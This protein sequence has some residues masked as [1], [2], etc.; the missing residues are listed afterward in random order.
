MA[1]YKKLVRDKIPE[2]CKNNGEEPVIRI[3]SDQEYLQELNKKLQEEMKEYYANSIYVDKYQYVMS[4]NE[5]IDSVIENSE[6]MKKS[7]MLYS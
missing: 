3:L 7:D 6:N 1:S 5:Y 4:Y 2:I